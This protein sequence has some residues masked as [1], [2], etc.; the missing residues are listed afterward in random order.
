MGEIALKYLSIPELTEINSQIYGYQ[1]Q[2]YSFDI[3]RTAQNLISAYGGL[4]PLTCHSEVVPEGST[5]FLRD[6]FP[7]LLQYCILFPAYH[8]A[9]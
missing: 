4:S 2:L 5:C 1:I 7:V 3:H 9:I 8:A 6:L